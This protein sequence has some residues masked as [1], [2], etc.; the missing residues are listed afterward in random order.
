MVQ[1]LKLLLWVSILE[2]ALR[3]ALKTPGPRKTRRG[4]SH[5]ISPRCHVS[6]GGCSSCL[7]SCV[8]PHE[9]QLSDTKLNFCTVL[10]KTLFG[11]LNSVLKGLHFINISSFM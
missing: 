8:P 6:R 1:K 11:N 2:A 10:A 5:K 9:L 7:H 3:A 4:K